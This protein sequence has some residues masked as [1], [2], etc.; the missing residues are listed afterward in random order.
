MRCKEI[1]LKQDIAQDASLAQANA[2]KH[3]RLLAQEPIPILR[4]AKHKAGLVT[5]PEDLPARWY[6]LWI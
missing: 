6:L 5:L 2:Q 1:N 3:S 4:L